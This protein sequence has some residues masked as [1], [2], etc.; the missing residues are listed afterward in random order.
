MSTTSMKYLSV[1]IDKSAFFFTTDNIGHSVTVRLDDVSSSFIRGFYYVVG[2]LK[3]S[4]H[5]QSDHDHNVFYYNVSVL[6]KSHTL[7]N[8]KIPIKEYNRLFAVFGELCYN[9]CRYAVLITYKDECKLL[10]FDDLDFLNGLIT[11]KSWLA[12]D[13]DFKL[14]SIHDNMKLCHHYITYDYVSSIDT[15]LENI[16]NILIQDYIIP[17]LADIIAGYYPDVCEFEGIIDGYEYAHC[18]TVCDF[19]CDVCMSSELGGKVGIRS[20]Y[21]AS[22]RLEVARE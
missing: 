20:P 16:R 21:K 17:D 1:T 3:L 8:Y 12:S 5:W 11:I 19:I 18:E 7:L 4:L 13:A 15:L 14:H 22:V 10:W 9:R 2:S 6:D